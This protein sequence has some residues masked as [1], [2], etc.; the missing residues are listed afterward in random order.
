MRDLPQHFRVSEDMNSTIM[1]VRITVT[2][3]YVPNL[4]GES[5]KV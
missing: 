1:R 3:V 5:G 4:M 2:I